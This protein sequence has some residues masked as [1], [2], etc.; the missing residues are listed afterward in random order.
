[1]NRTSTAP[2][3]RRIAAA[4][5]TLLL[6]SLGACSGTDATSTD[7]ATTVSGSTGTTATLDTSSIASGVPTLDD[8]HADDNDL[9]YDPSDATVISLEDGGSTVDGSGADVDGDVVS[10]TAPGTYLLS[11]TLSDGQVVVDSD[12]DG[13]VVL[14][15]DGVDLTSASSSPLVITEADE[16]VVVLADG[17]DNTLSDAA[18][19]GSDDEEEDAPNATLFSMADLTI[20]GE[21]SLTVHGLSNDAIT[22]K[23][24]LVVLSGEL[25]VDAVDDGIRGKDYLVVEDGTLEVDAGGDGLKADNEDVDEPGWILLDGGSVTV[26]AGSDGAAAVGAIYVVDGELDVPAS[27]EGLEAML[28]RITGGSVSVTASD[29][30]LNPTAGTA[31]G[32]AEQ[33]EDGVLLDISGGTVQVWAGSDGIDSNGQASITGGTVVVSSAAAMGG[34]GVFDVNGAFES[35][36][37]VALESAITEG[38]RVSLVDDSGTVVASFVATADGTP[39]VAAAGLVSGTAYTGSADTDADSTDGLSEVGSVTAAEPSVAMGR[40]A[41]GGP[42]G[43][44]GGGQGGP[45]GGP[46]GGPDGEHGGPP[47]GVEATEGTQS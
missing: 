17:S 34:N 33:A 14:V 35:P 45:G 8:T 43:G 13:K 27:E 19:S 37:V 30:G 26:T 31:E 36:G 47:P 16:A 7:S 1:M 6:V 5:S 10:I 24:G 38:Q 41:G 32:G 11:G 12:A 23:D 42:G 21:G 2:L 44:P 3:R 28:I 18:A 4:A 29:D 40:G 22:S 15:L 20:G 25:T 46:G 39:T 9:D